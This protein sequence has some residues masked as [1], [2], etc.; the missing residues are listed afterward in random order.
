MVSLVLKLYI[1]INF[2]II[3]L[4][5]ALTF[6][7]SIRLSNTRISYILFGVWDLISNFLITLNNQTGSLEGQHFKKTGTLVSL[8]EQN[9]VDCSTS[10]GNNGC[11]GGL[12][13]NAFEYIKAN[14]GIDTESSYP[15]TG[16]VSQS[17]INILDLVCEKSNKYLLFWSNSLIS[18]SKSYEIYIRQ[19]HTTSF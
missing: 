13:D 4:I 10:Y 6:H 19:P 12:M 15:Y 18:L 11:Q 17:S 14:K 9:L 8:S 16:R 2:F 3:L 5:I 1:Y 7:V